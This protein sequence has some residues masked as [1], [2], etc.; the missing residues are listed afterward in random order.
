[1][2][3]LITSAVS[4]S[5]YVSL[6]AACQT[7]PLTPSQMKAVNK[8]KSLLYKKHPERTGDIFGEHKQLFQPPAQMHESDFE[9]KHVPRRMKSKRQ[10]HFATIEST[11]DFPDDLALDLPDAVTSEPGQRATETM[12]PNPSDSA[13]PHANNDNDTNNENKSRT[14][15]PNTT[16][17]TS[18]PP[19]LFPLPSPLGK[20]HA[21]DPLNEAPLYLRVGSGH[22]DHPDS[23]SDSIAQSPAAAEFNIYDKAY[24]EE[25]AR[26][27]GV[28]ESALVYLTR[29]VGGWGDSKLGIGA[30]GRAAPGGGAGDLVTSNPT[31]DPDPAAVSDPAT[32]A[33]VN[34]P[35]DDAKS[36]TQTSA[37]HP[38]NQTPEETHE[39]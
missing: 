10:D 4:S 34:A 27:K 12:S 13:I 38:A 26:I 20:G 5:S 37:P 36:A 7:Q 24:R 32:A 25:V 2:P 17:T 18:T 19:S 35:D 29:R 31:D 16:T 21:H 14:T 1:M 3:L 11:K 6:S 33:D 39:A 28:S 22:A 30:G 15:P 23:D 9:A 8:F